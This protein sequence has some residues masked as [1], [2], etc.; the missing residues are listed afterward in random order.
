MFE[1]TLFIIPARGGSKGLPKK[2]IK[3]FL[4]KPLI[5]YSIE[6]ARLFVPD[7]NICLTTDD[8]SIVNCA[9]EIGLEVPF[10][11]PP[12]LA[13]DTADTFSVLQHAFQYYSDKYQNKFELIVLLQPTSPIREKFHF[14]EAVNLYNSTVDMVVSVCKAKSNPYFTL[15]EEDANGLLT[16]CKG[17]NSYSRRQDTPTVYEYNGSIYI[18]NP[19]VLITKTAFSEIN[20]KIK[21][22]MDDYFSVD[23]DT[24][25]DW[26]FAEYILTNK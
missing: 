24:I 14:E 7:E 8:E 10:L 16:V 19:N 5:H 4:G 11:R 22:L 13:T 12:N 23:L 9:K 17:N 2:N 3:L 26:K 25:N 1:N 21:Y 15:F 18:I 20:N 6:Y